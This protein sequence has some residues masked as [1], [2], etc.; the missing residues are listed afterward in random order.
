[1][2]SDSDGELPSLSAIVSRIQHQKAAPTAVRKNHL[3]IEDPAEE[4]IILKG[5]EKS[6]SRR[7]HPGPTVD[8][9]HAVASGHSSSSSVNA[10]SPSKQSTRPNSKKTDSA[11]PA[12]KPTLA[13]TLHP[14]SPVSHVQ[15]AVTANLESADAKRAHSNASGASQSGNQLESKAAPVPCNDGEKGLGNIVTEQSIS[16]ANRLLTAASCSSL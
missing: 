7:L 16:R 11:G 8:I 15:K 10:F 4:A 6:R 13:S 2:D 14:S 3:Y 5:K 9:R 1:M 12:Q